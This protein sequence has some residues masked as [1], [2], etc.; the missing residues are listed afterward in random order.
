MKILKHYY[1]TKI[2]LL[3]AIYGI[4]GCNQIFDEEEIEKIGTIQEAVFSEDFDFETGQSIEMSLPSSQ[5]NGRY[6][7]YLFINGNEEL[8][9]SFNSLTGIEKD[10]RIPSATQQVIVKWISAEDTKTSTFDVSENASV[11]FDLP[12]SRSRTS[13]E[14]CRDRLYAVEAS[15][16]GFWD[17]DLENPGYEETQLPNL[18]GGG[19]I[20]CALDQDNGYMYYNVG[21]TLYRYDVNA[22][23]FETVFT[24]NPFSGSYPR[25][26]Y[27]D[28]FFYMSNRN[29]MFKVDAS[30]NQVVGDYTISGFVNSTGGGDLAFASDG[31]LYLACFSGLYKFTTIDDQNGTATITRLSAE[32]FPY[33]LTSM[34]IDRKDDIYVGTNNSN[35]NLIRMSIEDGS[36]EIVK[37]YNHKIN[38]LTAWR[39][40][41]E[42]LGDEDSDGDGIINQLDD[43]PDDPEVAF[44]E[45][46][47]SE[48]GNGSLAFEDNWPSVGDYDFNDMVVN[49]RYIFV[50][51]NENKVVRVNLEFNLVAMGATYH[52]GFGITLP[53]SASLISSVSGYEV[54][55]DLVTINEKGLESGQSNTVIIVFDDAFDHMGNQE[56]VNTVVGGNSAPAK[57]FDIE[58]EFIEPIDATLLQTSEFNPFIFI[59]GD[60]T[61]ELHLSGGAPTD[62]FDTSFFGQMDDDSNTSNRKYRNR[63]NAPWAIDVLHSFRYPRE[64]N[65]IDEGYTRF[66]NWAS[67]NGDSY[68]DWYTDA[69]NNRVVNKLYFDD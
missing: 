28:G 64:R 5:V 39:C 34:A 53:V 67:S 22:E 6:E 14:V 2:L 33:Q 54:T 32:N 25:L 9:G 1:V 36:F 48:L 44:T 56:I 7:V 41:D 68:R 24:N 62:L 21:R 15:F 10:I 26:E 60:R 51:N 55:R 4:V 16:G 17:I 27:K 37:T 57:L 8:F 35:S 38:D 23:A 49:Y 58:I 30:T 31:T 59:N 65:R 40:S 66:M 46:T 63:N 69:P 29:R 19:S 61:R 11:D 52:N 18:S 45:Y 3:I 47:P 20:A 42:D 13:N 43:Y 50:M 12:Q